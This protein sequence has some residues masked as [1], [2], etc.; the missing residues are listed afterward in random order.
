VFE[1]V[2]PP[3][4]IGMPLTFVPSSGGGTISNTLAAWYFDNNFTDSSGTNNL[5]A[6]GSPAFV[7]DKNS[8]ANHAISF[9]G[10]SQ[11]AKS[12]VG[13][14]VNPLTT[15]FTFSTW[16]NC[17]NFGSGTD[18]RVVS[19]NI[20]GT[21]LWQFVLGN[22]GGA[23]QDFALAV[24]VGSTE[25]SAGTL[26]GLYSTGVWYQVV[27]EWNHTAK[28]VALWVNGGSV[29]VTGEAGFGIGA[30]DNTLWIGCRSDK[31]GWFTGSLDDTRIFSRL[32]TTNEITTIF[33][34]GP[35]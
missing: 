30:T 20:D 31:N 32:L 21:T 16:I 15:D 23:S 28:T 13:T 7:V 10:S 24:Y 35:Q 34:A 2:P 18:T 29:A 33:N 9:N 6:T 1:I 22:S 19:Q 5:T 11:Y 27:F 12:A 3:L 26:A 14:I 4:Y 8:V 25:F 17:A